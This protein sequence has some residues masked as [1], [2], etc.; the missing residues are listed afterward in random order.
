MSAPYVQHRGMEVTR[1]SI[2]YTVRMCTI[3]VYNSVQSR[4]TKPDGTPLASHPAG[5]ARGWAGWRRLRGL[6]C[7][8]VHGVWAR[9][10]GRTASS[11]PLGG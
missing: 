2:D 7:H 11:P 5:A 9:A 3:Q 1:N 10:R 6:L 8:L 4:K